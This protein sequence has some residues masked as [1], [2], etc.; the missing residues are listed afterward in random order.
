MN[1]R[2]GDAGASALYFSR[3]MHK[4]LR[5]FVHRFDYRVFSL[6]LDLAEIPRLAGRL[7][8]F[9]YNRFNLFAFY[10]RDHGPRDGGS[11]R[12]HVDAALRQ[13]DIDLAG[14]PVHLLCFPRVLGYVF[15][16]LSIYFC[17]HAD[18]SLRAILYEVRNTFGDMHSYLLPVERGRSPDDPI[19]QACDKDMYVSP[20]IGMTARYRFRVKEPGR[21]LSVLIRESTP[22]GELLVAAMNGR[23]VG[24]SDAGLVRAFF[25]HPLM[26]LKVMGA[27]HWQALW[28]WLKGAAF[29]RRPDP[30]AAPVSYPLSETPADGRS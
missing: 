18:G 19:N 28:L 22:E 13:A 30:P 16:P 3:V 15:N 8:L 21:R 7:R 29:H 5:P 10:D 6:W 14:G 25:G 26:T 23:R 17:R 24:L 1:E 12:E 11:L 2:A 4:R 27:I 9:S 20:F